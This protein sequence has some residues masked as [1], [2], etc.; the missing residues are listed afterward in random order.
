MSDYRHPDS[1]RDGIPD[2]IEVLNGLNPI[3]S[4]DASLDVDGD[5]ILNIDE[6]KFG[7]P[8]SISN[9]KFE[10]LKINSSMEVD[11]ATGCRT[12]RFTNLPFYG[13]LS[14]NQFTVEIMEQNFAG[15]IILRRV[16][17]FIYVEDFIIGNFDINLDS[18]LLYDGYSSGDLWKIA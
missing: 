13:R 8:V 3:D 18:D 1:D 7:Q 10:N 16:N 9:D 15:E 4:R 17:Y 14:P 5:G 6:I 12:L 2:R 11:V